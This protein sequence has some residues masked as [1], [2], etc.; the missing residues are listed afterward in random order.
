MLK[1][2]NKTTQET[3]SFSEADMLNMIQSLKDYTH[4]SH[5]I[6]GFDEREPKEF[7]EIW[8]EQQIKTIYQN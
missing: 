8:K 7:L 1:L 4:E 5:S 6:L 2:V 3:N